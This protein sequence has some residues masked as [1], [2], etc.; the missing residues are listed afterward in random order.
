[1]TV[2]G[3]P[4]SG[5]FAKFTG[6]GLEGRTSVETRD[7]LG[8]GTGDSPQFVAINFNHASDTTM[9]RVEAGKISIEGKVLVRTAAQV[10]A[11]NDSYIK[12]QADLTCDGTDD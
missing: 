12:T 11:A 8:L 6:S 1:V 2:D 9:T 7:D 5:E 10:I 3:D 4:N